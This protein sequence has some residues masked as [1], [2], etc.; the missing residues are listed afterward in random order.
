[1]A[2]V[3]RGVLIKAP[4]ERVFSYVTDP[5]NELEWLPSM[6]DV[7]DITGLGI[8]QTWGWTYKMLGMSF[9][10]KTEVTDFASN[11]RYVYKSSGGITSTWTYSFK[12]EAGGTRLSLAVEYTIPIPVL[13]KVAERLVLSQNERE[14]DLAIANIKGR[15][16]SQAS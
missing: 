1:V 6:T 16:E 8:G 12:P 7:R 5:K 13:G 14:A 3:E 15:L 11:S 2:K 10:G 4:V 9:K